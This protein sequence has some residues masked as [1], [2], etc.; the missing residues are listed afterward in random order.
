MVG[1]QEVSSW[2]LKVAKREKRREST[3]EGLER[4]RG[5]RERSVFKRSWEVIQGTMHQFNT[6]PAVAKSVDLAQTCGLGL[7]PYR[8]EQIIPV[9]ATAKIQLSDPEG[10]DK[11]GRE[12]GRETERREKNR[13]REAPC[14]TN[15]NQSK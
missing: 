3:E 6:A 4:L 15:L 12:G 14:E 9:K 8:K 13:D 1:G 5:P 11:R 7:E 2:R 10:R